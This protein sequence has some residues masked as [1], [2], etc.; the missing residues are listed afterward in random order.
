MPL[1]SKEKGQVFPK[2]EKK[3]LSKQQQKEVKSGYRL[4]NNTTDSDYVYSKQ[5]A[6]SMP[7]SSGIPAKGKDSF[8]VGPD[9]NGDHQQNLPQSA[10]FKHALHWTIVWISLAV[11]FAGII[12]IIQ[13][14]DNALLFLTGYAIE[15]SL[16]MDNL[17]VFLI[18][19]SSLAI[20]YVYQQKVLIV[21]I[22][23]AIAM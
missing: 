20:P 12:Y 6:S 22:I 23:S 17:F 2:K 10:T 16:S 15:K 19:F 7:S 18:I 3:K 11:V 5:A 14:Y 4:D 1:F 21:G 9:K 13:G 8:P